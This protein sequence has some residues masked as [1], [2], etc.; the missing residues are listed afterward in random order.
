MRLGAV[1]VVFGAAAV[2]CSPVGR[3]GGNIPTSETDTLAMAVEWAIVSSE[4][5]VAD[6][7]GMLTSIAV[8]TAGNV[9]ASD[10]LAARVWA[11]DS[12]GRSLGAIGQRGKG[13]GEFEAPTG[14]GVSPE[15]LLYVRDVYRVSVFGPNE[16]NV[17]SEL[18]ST[19]DGPT[20]ADWTSLR[21]TRF[22]SE[23]FFYYPG[24][25]W[26]RDTHIRPFVIRYDGDGSVVD[27]TFIPPEQTALTRI[28]FYRVGPSGGR[29]LLGLQHVP[30]AATPSWDITPQ[31]TVVSGS[32]AQYALRETTR[33]GDS[34]RTFARALPRPVV[35]SDEWADSSS[36]L[37]VRL[38]SVPVPL[39]E[40]VGLSPQVRELDLPTSYPYYASAQVGQDG[41]IWVRRWLPHSAGQTVFDVFEPDGQLRIAVSL[42]D[43]VPVEPMPVLSLDGVIAVVRN[44]LTDEDGLKKY[45]PTS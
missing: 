42:P 45:V 9:Y 35:P 2:G 31:G 28:P 16:S 23:G 10:R 8:D 22:D 43:F 4:N 25:I 34:L 40:V 12:R 15:G 36:A 13:P 30:F 37:R 32:G 29:L 26:E 20:Y 6:S 14:L 33:Q 27:T 1:A 18:R 41:R 39:H 3:E 21:P 7:F 44:P 24:Y 11:F 38:D 17:L 5:A 19:F